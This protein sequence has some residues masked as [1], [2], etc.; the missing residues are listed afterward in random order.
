M[1]LPANAA[2]SLL[3]AFCLSSC[4]GNKLA[5]QWPSTYELKKTQIS[6]RGPVTDSLAITRGGHYRVNIET[7]GTGVN[8]DTDEP[9]ILSGCIKSGERQINVRAPNADV[10]VHALRGEWTLRKGGSARS[11]RFLRAFNA[12]RIQVMDSEIIASEGIRLDGGDGTEVN[13]TGNYAENIR[14]NV[15]RPPYAQFVQLANMKN[16]DAEIAH[17]RVV[18]VPGKSNPEDIISIFK[19]NG[20]SPDNPIW[21]HHNDIDGAY[22]ANPDSGKFSGGGIMGGDGPPTGNR[23]RNVLIEKN[24]VTRTTN[25]GIAFTSG[26]GEHLIVRNN[27]VIHEAGDALPAN[28]VGLVGFNIHGA[29]S[30]GKPR[31]VDNEVRWVNAKGKDNPWWLPDAED[32]GNSSDR[33][34]SL[35]RDKVGGS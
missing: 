33:P 16:V 2:F 4:A 14:Q 17:N 23:V 32:N 13:I 9:V 26:L 8:I 6:C 1:G 3:M 30:F 5:S 21:I 34:C 35:Y 7:E 19:S 15:R 28:N 22:P 11:G 12:A 29:N 18:N 24:R 10:T 25:Y 27:C 31:F 20:P